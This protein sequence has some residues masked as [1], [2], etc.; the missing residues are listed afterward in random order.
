M[1]MSPCCPE[2]GALHETRYQSSV[3][4]LSL[5]GGFDACVGP[6]WQLYKT[7]FATA[8]PRASSRQAPSC[9]HPVQHMHPFP[10]LDKTSQKSC[11]VSLPHSCSCVSLKHCGCRGMMTLV[12]T[13]APPSGLRLTSPWISASHFLAMQPSLNRTSAGYVTLCSPPLCCSLGHG[14]FYTLPL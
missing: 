13:A 9:I 10:D 12:S 1:P 4:S 2:H 11:L 14:V 8:S 3:N 7:H 6:A 5:A